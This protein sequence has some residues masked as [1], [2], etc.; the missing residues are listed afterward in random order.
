MNEIEKLDK[1]INDLKSS[2]D[3]LLEMIK[4]LKTEND[5]LKNILREITLYT[6]NHSTDKRTLYVDKLL[7]DCNKAEKCLDEIEE[8]CNENKYPSDE[9]DFVAFFA[10]KIL[11]KI[12]E[13]KGEE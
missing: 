12:K 9:Y 7:L 13:V 4:Q 2:T 10:N 5:K 11:R 1:N 8:I 6:T 3:K